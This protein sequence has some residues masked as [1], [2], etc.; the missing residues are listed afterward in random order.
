MMSPFPLIGV[1]FTS[2]PRR[3]KPITVAHGYFEASRLYVSSLE[4]LTD[5]QSFDGLL[6]RPGPWLMAL[7]LPFGL[8][9]ELVSQLDWPMDWPSLVAHCAALGKEAF[10]AALNRV[11][12]SRPYGARYLH[13]S[14][15][16]PARS[17]S[18]MKLVNPPV[19]LMFLAGAPRLAAAGL[20]LPGGMQAGDSARIAL[21]AYPGLLARRLGAGSYKQ[22]DKRKQTTEQRAMREMMLARLAEPSNPLG[23]ALRLES[24]IHARAIDDASGDSLDAILALAQAAWAWQ[25][26]DG[27]YGLPDFN[28]VEGWIVSA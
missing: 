10:C 20:H 3:A 4:A 19:G 14:T 18:P 15:D 1:D 11:R 25:R 2:A 17:H 8:P 24:P 22:D 13:R 27:N 9:A 26:G 7:D 16:Q 28:P 6:M 12:E 5:W 23:F 21:E